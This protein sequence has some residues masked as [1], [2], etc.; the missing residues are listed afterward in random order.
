MR[1]EVDGEA[2]EDLPVSGERGLVVL[3]LD[4]ANYPTR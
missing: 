2:L 4:L 3:S 1:L